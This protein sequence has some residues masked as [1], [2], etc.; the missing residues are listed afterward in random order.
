MIAVVPSLIKQQVLKNV[1]V[2][3]SSLS[4]DM[5][6]EI[7]VPFYMSVY[8]FEVVNPE[9]ILKGGQPRVRERG[10]YVY[11][12]FRHKVNITFND[13]DTVSFREHRR[14]HFQPEKSRGSES[15]YIVLPNIM[16]MAAAAMVEHRPMSLR[17]LVTLALTT[18]GERAF[19]NRTVGEVMWGYE[20]PLVDFMDKYFPNTIPFKGKFGL[21]AQMNNSDSEIFTVFTGMKNLS[22]I[23]QVDRWKGLSQVTGIPMN[24]SVK[25]QLSLYIKSIRGIGQTGKIQPVVLPLLWF[26]QSGAM[27]GETLHTFYMQLVLMP[28]ILHYAQYVL[29]ALGGALL[30]IPVVY[31]VRSQD[32]CFLFWSGSKKGS[33]DKEAMQAYSESLMT[34]PPRGAVLQEARL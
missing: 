1:R 11:R 23:H 32:K 3:P 19:M 26:G 6:K 31:Q 33:K 4:F 20:D 2:D 24:C 25:L 5:W 29:L 34:S 14:Y 27:E 8:F 18:L 28:K 13:N 10:P 17:L 22:R 15:D 12:E 9:E 21:F 7:P 16:V 30:L